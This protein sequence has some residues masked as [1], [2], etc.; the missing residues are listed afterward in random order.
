[1]SGLPN[2][3]TLHLTPL[4]PVHLGTD[5]DYTPT[6]YVIEDDALFEFDHRALTA[7][8]ATDRAVL[9]RIL[10]GRPQPRMLKQV[11]AY[12]FERRDR[13]IPEAVNVVKVCAGVA[14]L[15]RARVGRAANVESG[16]REV[17]NRLE[18]E[19]AAYDPAD[20]RLY[21]PGSGLKGAI[22]TALLDR[23]NAGAPLPPDLRG[24][25]HASRKL[26][27]RLFGYSM[28]ELHKDP[29]RLVQVG[30]CRW[31]GPDDLN[32]AEILF[33][34]N[35]AKR[36]AARHGRETASRAERG[37]LYQL[38]ECLA[39]FRVRAFR[40]TLT[41][42]DVGAVAGHPKLPQRRFGFAD[43][44]AAC[45]AFYRPLFD[46]ELRRLH[47]RGLLDAEW[48]RTVTGLLDD[49]ALRRRFETGQAFLVRVG[50]HSGAESVTLNGVR[51][52]RIKQ[53]QGRPPAWEPA[54][55][56][57]WLA[58]AEEHDQAHLIPFGWVLAELGDDLPP[59]ERAEALVSRDHAEQ[60]AWLR[61]V[62]ERQRRL[63]ERL[64][65]AREAEAARARAEAERRRRE[66]E[67]A[68]RLARM[69]PEERLIEQV[70]EQLECD[71]RA[72]RKEA[73]GELNQKR[74]ELLE[75]ALS[76]DDPELRRR[77][78]ELLA[79]TARWL[80]WAKKRRQEIREKLARLTP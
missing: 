6:Q 51:S 62:R 15:Y 34:V 2:T 72:G 73:G 1:M 48:R 44:A 31:Y 10:E 32:S 78:A 40:G 21:V 3:R 80:P 77:A 27:E 58:A 50:R 45:N 71:R 59:W 75:A 14:T 49:P 22:R 53:G 37:G 65:Q 79:E 24:D 70:R 76:W 52:I 23:R 20:R 17:H 26:Q 56:T 57:W 41:V 61:Q 9:M 29:M 42:I 18:I 54:A 8:P 38:L 39:P 47:E 66:Q 13:L 63:G 35:R 4:S 67:R 28:R 16:G 5:E 36:P 11:Q 69:H 60:A 43:I 12:F 68:E 7:L 33:A 25:R 64:R 30:D 19:R 46:D 55:R 74:L